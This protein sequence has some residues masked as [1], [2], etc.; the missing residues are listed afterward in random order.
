MPASS[1]NEWLPSTHMANVF[2]N[3]IT[4]EKSSTKLSASLKWKWMEIADRATNQIVRIA[5]FPPL[6]YIKEDAT[7]NNNKPKRRIFDFIMLFLNCEKIQ[8]NR[9][10]SHYVLFLKFVNSLKK[11]TR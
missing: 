9:I 8:N 2:I 5:L 10:G 4:E 7:V 6:K 3:T 1:I 11:L